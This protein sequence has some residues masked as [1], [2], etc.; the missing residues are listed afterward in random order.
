MAPRP[1]EVAVLARVNA[2]LAPVQ[3]LLRND[4]VPVNGGVSGRFLQRGGV[5]AALA[6]LTVATA[7]GRGTPGCSPAGGG[8]PSQARHERS[9]LDL[10]GKQS[11]VDGLVSLA[12]WLE[13]KGSAR[14]AGKVRDLADDVE[15]GPRGRPR[16][17][18]GE[19]LAVLR[20]QIGDGGLDA[21]ATA[22]DR[23]SHGAISAHGDDLDALSELADLE[24]DPSRFP[25]W[26]SEQ[27]S[28]PAIKTGSPWRRSMP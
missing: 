28:A 14:E 9:L 8:A 20:S 18:D 25:A 22:L 6:W 11:S 10:V 4:G 24:S 16:R 21:S 5:R 23:W 12:D 13:G 17:D 3:V 1:T 7:P 26:L 2:S 19:I 27:L 15:A